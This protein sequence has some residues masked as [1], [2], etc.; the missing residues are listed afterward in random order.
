MPWHD[1][2]KGEPAMH[3]LGNGDAELL[4]RTLVQE[5]ALLPPSMSMREKRQLC[6]SERTIGSRTRAY[7]LGLGMSSG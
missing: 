3:Q 5:V 7:S 1:A 4:Q 2:V 6:I